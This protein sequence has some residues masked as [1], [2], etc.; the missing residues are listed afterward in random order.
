MDI[1]D[2][3]TLVFSGGGIR[4]ASYVG[5]LLAFT[6]TYQKHA[7]DHFSTF[8]GSSV[9]SLVALGC[10]L[11]LD[12]NFLFE[13]FSEIGT[14]NLFSKDPTWLLTHYSL[15]NGA[16]LKEFIL[17]LLQMKGIS[18]NITFSE[19]YKLTLKTLVV[20]VVDLNT[21]CVHYLSHDNEGQHIPVLKAILGSMALPP[22]FPAVQHEQYSF[23]DGGLLDS[24]PIRNFEK[25]KTLGMCTAWYIEKGNCMKDISS[26]YTRIFSILQ[27]PLHSSQAQ[28]SSEY[29]F[30]VFIDLGSVTADSSSV[31]PQELVF[32]GYRAAVARFS[33]S[34]NQTCISKQDPTKF[35]L[36]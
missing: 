30:V 8:V 36:H 35:L 32:R 1:S 9:G 4:G 27:L 15:N 28:V 23:I 19:L 12:M 6:D 20:T 34:S 22:I 3:D 26:Y 7:S 13:K 24:F 11:S 21:A 14:S 18:E 29:P 25:T 31:E 5:A 2:L 17:S 16:L 10:T 33:G